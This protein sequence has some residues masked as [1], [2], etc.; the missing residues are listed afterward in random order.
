MG[1]VAAAQFC[2]EENACRGALNLDGIP[3]YG[4]MIDTR[5][6][7]PILMVYSARPGRAGANDSI[8][9]PASSVYYR[10]DVDKTR[11]LDFADMT[12]WGGPLRDRPVLGSI[13][14]IRAT[15]ITRTIVVQ[16]F[17]QV[18]SGQSSRVLNSTA[19]MPIPG[20]RVQKMPGGR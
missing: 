20:V 11:H 8:Y 7:K 15:S 19:P 6:N 1:G 14:P 16:F 4:P 9:G 17:D 10:V 18:L 5:L 3:Q 2:A 12:L 13:D